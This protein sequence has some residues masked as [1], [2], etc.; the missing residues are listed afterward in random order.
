[1][2]PFEVPAGIE[3]QR[4]Y[5]FAAPGAAG[6]EVWVNRYQISQPTGSHH[7]N[8]FRVKTIQNLGGNPGDV[9]IDGECFV[10]SNWSDWPLV[11]NSQQ[12]ANTSWTLPDGVGAR[13]HGGER[14]MLQ[15]HWVNA[16]TQKTL[17]ARHMS[18]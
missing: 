17:R 13:F 10:S 2:P 5:F 8:L 12:A 7:M 1:M 15:T 9:V 14:L 11:V 4:C 6:D 3:T 18:R 16:T